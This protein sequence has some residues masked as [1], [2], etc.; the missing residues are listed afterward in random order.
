VLAPALRR[1]YHLSLAQTGLLI[2]MSLIGSLVS[3]IPWGQA[4]DRFGERFV[5]LVG[6]LGCGASLIGAA[7]VHRCAALA[8]LLALAGAAGASVQSA[9]GRAVMHWFAP[10]ER[11]LAL[12]MRQ[13]AIPLS[14]FVVSLAIPPIEH[15]GG[16]AWGF[17]ALG[18]ACL[19]GAVLGALV[20]R[21]GPQAEPH[22]QR[23]ERPLRDRRLWTLSFGSSLVI[24]PQLCVVGFTVLLLHERRGLTTSAAA[25]AS[26]SCSSSRSVRGSAP[27]AG[28]TSSEA[29]SARCAGSRS[30]RPP[31]SRSPGYCSVRRSRSFCRRSSRAA[32]SR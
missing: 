10:A 8:L 4:T 31:S 30:P 32:S 17:G 14:G 26:P 18:I 19:A 16:I 9:S 25:A 6:L 23:S 15:A 13:T 22:A 7:F 1:A 21:E 27:D 5:L 28:P 20:L 2:S 12:A 24:A 11:G 29:G 3:L